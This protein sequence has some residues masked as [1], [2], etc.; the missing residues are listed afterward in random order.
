MRISRRT[1]RVLPV[2][3]DGRVLLLLCRVL[4]RRDDHFWLSVGG[5]LERGEGLA[6]AAVRELREEVG[7]VIDPARLSDSLG[8]SVIVDSV[9]GLLPVTTSL[10]YFA[11]A[12]D[13]TRVSFA[14]QS[15]WERIS[16]REHAWLS[17]EEIEARPE[18]AG[19]PELPRMMRA[20]V[21]VAAA[22]PGP[23]LSPLA[24]RLSST[25]GPNWIW[26]TVKPCS[27]G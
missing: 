21:A 1:A 10:T 9:F 20:A 19:D 16:I 13:D 8:T 24:G 11:V 25:P 5:G 23:R 26:A 12:V 6:P 7:M 22:H 17:P 14:G 4:V 3:P 15:R 2:D 18:R 27:L